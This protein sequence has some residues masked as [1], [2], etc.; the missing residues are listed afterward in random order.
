[1]RRLYLIASLLF[2][3][4]ICFA[5]QNL[6]GTIYG[7][8]DARSTKTYKIQVGSYSYLSNAQN[9]IARLQRHNLDPVRENYLQYTRVLLRGIPA[10]QVADTLTTI[11]RAGF[12]EVWIQQD[13]QAAPSPTT[14]QP[15]SPAQTRGTLYVIPEYESG[16]DIS[17]VNI[18]ISGRLLVKPF[19]G[20]PG[21]GESPEIDVIERAYILQLYEPVTFISSNDTTT[22]DEIQLIIYSDLDRS[23]LIIG[24]NYVV[25]GVAFHALTGHHHTPIMLDVSRIT[26]ESVQK[27]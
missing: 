23:R 15:S 4:F 1:M 3:S 21:Y 19:H 14:R 6:P 25:D 13:T 2:I 26:L 7:S 18:N 12:N 8:F 10:S 5:Q 20:P 17:S 22:V 11:K 27:R 9:T 24:S 16:G